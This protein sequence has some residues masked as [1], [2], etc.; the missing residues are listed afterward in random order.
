MAPIL[1]CVHQKFGISSL[2]DPFYFFIFYYFIFIFCFLGLH[3][4]RVEGPGPGVESDLQLP[5][6]AIATAVWDLSCVCDLQRSSGQHWI[7]NPMSKARDGIPHS[8]R[9]QLAETMETSTPPFLKVD[10]KVN[11]K[12]HFII[13]RTPL[14]WDL[15]ELKF[16]S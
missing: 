16:G 4:Q 5:T 8:Y 13:V 6:H 2:S 9:Y 14:T 3:P 12:K 10:I 11:T 15:F 1:V 7:L